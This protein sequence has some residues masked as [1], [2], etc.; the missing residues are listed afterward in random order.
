M[1]QFKGIRKLGEIERLAKERGYT[2]DESAFDKGADYIV[3][4]FH[5]KADNGEKLL[6]TA[7]VFYPS[8]VFFLHDEHGHYFGSSNDE[9]LDGAK[10]FDD[11]MDLLYLPLED[12][13]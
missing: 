12:S 3:V 5:V 9:N 7:K 10:W 4:G 11:L 2:V 6:T 13:R 1:K 8:G